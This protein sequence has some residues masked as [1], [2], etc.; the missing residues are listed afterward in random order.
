MEHWN[1]IRL[2]LEYFVFVEA[3]QSYSLK[4]ETLLLQFH[5]RNTLLKLKRRKGRKKGRMEG[6][7]RE[8][9]VDEG[10]ECKGGRDMGKKEGEKEKRGKGEV[11]QIRGGKKMRK[12]GGMGEKNNQECS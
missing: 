1:D 4:L 6:R 11:G 10:R 8:L 9:R 3:H 5:I 2:I 12:K 7:G